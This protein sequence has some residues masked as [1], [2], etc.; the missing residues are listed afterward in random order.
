MLPPVGDCNICHK[1]KLF[2][3]H[4]MFAEGVSLESQPWH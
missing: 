4:G 1:I 2:F 3:C